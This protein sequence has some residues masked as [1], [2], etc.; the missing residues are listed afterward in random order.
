MS[1]N[2]IG[3]SGRLG[4]QIIRN[5]VCSL[6]AKKYDLQFIYDYVTPIEEL[7]IELYKDGKNYHYRT[8]ELKDD[9][10]LRYLLHDDMGKTNIY[11]S[12]TF[13]QNQEIADFLRGYFSSEPVKQQ[14][15]NKNKYADRY[16]NNK[17]VY[18]HVR[19]GDAVSYCPSYDY[20]DKVLQK[21]NFTQG[22][23]SSD[24]IDHEICQKLI[25]NYGLIPM[26]NK[27]EVDTIMFASTCKHIVLTNGTF[28][29]FMGIFGWFS[30]IYYP[31]LN[32]RPKYHGDIYG[33]PDWI[34]NEY[35]G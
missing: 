24:T 33:F 21:L 32:L 30:T 9:D 10:F 15:M 12:N 13:F 22:Y 31:N 11:T 35:S 27:D 14:I 16:N 2:T 34:M 7:G 1:N 18:V 26:I 5:V 28:G 4:N 23:I 29:F 8:I 17:D 6:L 25:A 20:Y 3:S 19:L